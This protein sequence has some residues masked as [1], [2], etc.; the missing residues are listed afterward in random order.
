MLLDSPIPLLIFEILKVSTVFNVYSLVASIGFLA[1]FWA[2]KD[3]NVAM[4]C[5]AIVTLLITGFL[6]KVLTDSLSLT[7]N[8]VDEVVAAF[9][10]LP[11]TSIL[12]VSIISACTFIFWSVRNHKGFMLT[13]SL[14]IFLVVGIAVYQEIRLL[15]L[16]HHP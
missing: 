9:V 14:L 1:L 2:L 4:F 3:H 16:V 13:Y 15:R 7:I 12:P 5:F 8:S 11:F 6:I 10:P